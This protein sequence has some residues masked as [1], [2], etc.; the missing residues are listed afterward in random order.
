MTRSSEWVSLG[1]PDKVADYISCFLLDRY[2]E[3]DPLT[4]Y[5]VEVLI[6][7]RRVFLAGEVSSR[8]RFSYK[9]LESFVQAAVLQIGYDRPYEESWGGANAICGDDLRVE[10][11]ISAQSTDIA[12]GVDADGWGDQG[13]FWG[14]AVDDPARGFLPADYWLAREI[15]R[16]LYARALAG[17]GGLDIKTLV[18]VDESGDPVEVVAAVPVRGQD[19]SAAVLREI[20]AMLPDPSVPVVLNG[21]GAFRV[22]GPVGDSGVT[23]RKLAVDFYGGNCR[24][25]GGS[26]W[27]K[28]ATKADVTLNVLA[29][30]L[31]RQAVRRLRVPVAYCALSCCIG[32]R[33]VRVEIMDGGHRPLDSYVLD[34]PPA[35]FIEQNCLREP[36]FA[37]L[38]R[39]GIL[40]AAD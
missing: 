7:D 20:R 19:E 33:E 4:R 8:A 35:Y 15:G 32:R 11:E 10:A 22:H 12:R 38:C 27:G 14:M 29:R 3:E 28:D 24:V 1:H 31:A 17:T 13:I 18:T 30:R 26:P 16:K 6:K 39:D 34:L 23:G 2:L 36:V 37:R 21:T 9:D 25:G 40:S 5:A